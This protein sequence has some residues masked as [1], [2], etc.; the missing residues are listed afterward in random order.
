MIETNNLNSIK[1]QLYER[2]ERLE[3]VVRNMN[4]PSRLFDLLKEVDEALA[5]MDNGTYGLCEVCHD[6]IEMD[7][8]MIDPLVTVCLDH[9]N[10]TQKRS[11]ELDLEMA[12]KI[13]RGLL[14]KNN[15]SINGWEFSYYYNP[16]HAVGG[17][18]CDLIS[19]DSDSLLF[20]LGDV[21]G[22]G[23]SASL[24][25]S[26]L[27]ALIRSL[28]SFDLPL[29]EI[30]K[31]SNRLFCEST[32]LSNYATMVFGKANTR[33]EVE[34]CVAGHNPPLLVQDG[35]LESI[36]ATGIP[37]GLFCNF[38]YEVTKFTLEPGD[39]ILLYTDGLTE[40]AI[41]EIEYGEKRLQEK[42]LNTTKLS[43]SN[44]IDFLIKDQKSYL[45]N[46]PPADDVTLAV[47]KKS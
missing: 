41:N 47:L 10:V 28:I 27:H 46:S 38:D 42:L 26:Q 30:A 40:S 17:D 43:P 3:N 8:L 1:E 16:M 9:L 25:T 44:I 22:K 34:I 14:P 33:G 24:M 13:Q 12:A 31:K 15:S 7:R 20:V 4:D 5:R 37:V 18:F 6:C 2:K 45:Q 29:T 32:V 39:F 23:V 11:L 35:R 21:S 36:H 19:L